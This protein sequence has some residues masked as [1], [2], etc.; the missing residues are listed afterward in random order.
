MLTIQGWLIVVV[1]AIHLSATPLVRG[2]VAGQVNAQQMA[3]IW[4]PFALSFVVL[5]ILLIPIGL[6]T[7]YCARGIRRRESWAWVIA[8]MNALAVLT[9][10]VALLLIMDPVYFRA[11]P[12]LVASILITAVGVSMAWPLL[13]VRREI[14]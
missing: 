13:W 8:M 14:S 6:S 11:V 4:P 9:L 10:P 7:V 5:G 3:M 2:F 12:F 1:A